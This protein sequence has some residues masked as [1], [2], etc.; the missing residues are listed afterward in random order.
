[1]KIKDVMSQRPVFIKGDEFLTK[2]RQVMR[3]CRF[4]S[5]P[6]VDEQNR[7]R[8]VITIQDVLKITSTK[9]NLTV[10]GFTRATPAITPDMEVEEAA[11]AMIEA[12]ITR[13]PVVKSPQNPELVGMLSIVDLFSVINLSKLAGVKVRDIMTANVKVSSPEEPVGKIW[14]NMIE[15]GISGFPVVRK[16]RVIGIVT[17]SDIVKSG[18]IRIRKEDERQNLSLTPKVEKVMKTPVFTIPPDTTVKAAA[19]LMF[20]HDI[21]RIPVVENGKLAGIIDRYDIMKAYMGVVG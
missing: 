2:A 18:Y 14:A 7:V 3:D 10:D 16:N 20:K 13:M 9:S 8:G 1:M 5:L 17:R 21:G 11:K 4:R 15:F 19:E 12:E 6:V